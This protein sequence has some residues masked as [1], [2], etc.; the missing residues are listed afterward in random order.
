MENFSRRESNL[1]RKFHQKFCVKS[2]SLGLEGF[3]DELRSRMHSKSFAV[4]PK[5]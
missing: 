4:A 5:L 1:H 3:C 2:D